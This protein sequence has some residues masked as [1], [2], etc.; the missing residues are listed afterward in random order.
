VSK[1]TRDNNDRGDC[2]DREWSSVQV[3]KKDCVMLLC[4]SLAFGSWCSG[5]AQTIEDFCIV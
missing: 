3:S 1:G 4:A 2:D 5:L